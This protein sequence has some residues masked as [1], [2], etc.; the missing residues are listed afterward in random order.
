MR[1]QRRRCSITGVKI[2]R[3]VQIVKSNCVINECSISQCISKLVGEKTCDQ[4]FSDYAGGF[5]EFLI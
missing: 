1:E 2:E 3:S 4:F 5:T